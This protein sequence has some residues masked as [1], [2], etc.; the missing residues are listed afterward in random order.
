MFGLGLTLLSRVPCRSAK[1]QHVAASGSLTRKT[2]SR[3]TCIHSCKHACINA[4][5][6]VGRQV[7]RGVCVREVC[8]CVYAWL[9]GK[10]VCVRE[11]G[12][13][14]VREVCTCMHACM[15]IPGGL[16]LVRSGCSAHRTRT[17]RETPSANSSRWDTEWREGEGGGTDG[18]E[19]GS[20]GRVGRVFVLH[21]MGSR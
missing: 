21:D 13:G 11:R 1:S 7:G 19:E 16:R 12:G 10:Q 4:C 6:L 9:V 15:Q 5:K 17:S 20:R 14:Y 3:Y 8:T 18:E 2:P